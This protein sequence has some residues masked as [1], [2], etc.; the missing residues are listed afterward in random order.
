MLWPAGMTAVDANRTIVMSQYLD[1]DDE[2]EWSYLSA[3]GLIRPKPGKLQKVTN[4]IKILR[5]WLLLFIEVAWV[6]NDPQ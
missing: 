6:G 5:E 1:Y 4:L 2:V 3:V